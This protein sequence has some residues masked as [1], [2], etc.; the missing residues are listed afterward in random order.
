MLAR[1]ESSWRKQLHTSRDSIRTVARVRDVVV[2]AV[3]GMTHVEAIHW[4]TARQRVQYTHEL[5]VG[6]L[7]VQVEHIVHVRH[8]GS[9]GLTDNV[10]VGVVRVAVTAG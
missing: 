2:I 8:E 10:N 5:A 4:Q 3:A 6:Q 9:R 7:L 1:F